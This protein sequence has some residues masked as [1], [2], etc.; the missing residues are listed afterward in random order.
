M[1]EQNDPFPSTPTPWR[2]VSFTDGMVVMEAPPLVGRHV[3]KIV[4]KNQVGDSHLIITAV[5]SHDALVAACEAALP[6]LKSDIE[7]AA[8]AEPLDRHIA[9]V[10]QLESALRLAKGEA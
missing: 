5:N 8:G 4:S 7:L 10:S 2:A 6:L 9:A 1:T 3:C